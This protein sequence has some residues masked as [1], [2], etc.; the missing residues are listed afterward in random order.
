M[1]SIKCQP[2]SLGLLTALF[3]PFFSFLDFNASSSPPP[4]FE[5]ADATQVGGGG[6]PPMEGGGGNPPMEGG[7]GN[8]PMEGGGGNPSI[9]GDAGTPPVF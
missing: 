8:P 2:V 4:D 9:E 1:W 5:G 6:N 3:L 7:G